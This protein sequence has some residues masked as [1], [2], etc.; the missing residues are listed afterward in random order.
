MTILKCKLKSFIDFI[1][2]FDNTDNKQINYADSKNLDSDETKSDEKCC[3]A[4]VDLVVI[5]IDST[6][7]TPRIAI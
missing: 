5:I 3:Y 4:I 6:D 1:N 7:E 2:C